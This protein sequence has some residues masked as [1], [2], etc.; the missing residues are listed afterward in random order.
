MN[1]RLPLVVVF[2]FFLAPAIAQSSPD[3]ITGTWK[4]AS[5]SRTIEIY[6][7]RGLY[8]GKTIKDDK[9]SGGKVVIRDLKFEP[10]NKWI[11]KLISSKKQ[12]EYSCTIFLLDLDKM[13]IEA[14][15]GLIAKSREWRRVK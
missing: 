5:G 6:Q 9:H 10:D 2:A 3:A 11:G 13:R 14:S 7:E 15:N 8:Y 12:Q 4:N 1:W